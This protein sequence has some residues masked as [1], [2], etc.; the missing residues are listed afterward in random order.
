MARNLKMSVADFFENG[1]D[2]CKRL[3]TIGFQLILA[4][5]KENF[6]IPSVIRRLDGNMF[7]IKLTPALVCFNLL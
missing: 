3:A 2:L 1:R 6:I 5:R 4:G 7:N